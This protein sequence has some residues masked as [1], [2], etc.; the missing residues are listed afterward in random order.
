MYLFITEPRPTNDRSRSVRVCRSRPRAPRRFPDPTLQDIRAKIG[1]ESAIVFRP[2]E[3]LL[4]PRPWFSGRVVLI[5]DTVHATTPHL[6]AGPCIGIED[7]LVLAEEL[8]RAS[9]VGQAL[10]A[11][12][13]AAGSAAGWSSRTPPGSAR[14]R[15]P[16]ATKPSTHR[17]CATASW[18][19]RRRAEPH[20]DRRRRLDDGGQTACGASRRPLRV[21][22][23]LEGCR[24]TPQA[25][26]DR[27]VHLPRERRVLGPAAA[28]AE[29]HLPE[30]R[31]DAAGVSAHAARHQA[32][33]LSRWR[34]RRGRM[35]DADHAQRHPPGRALALPFH[36]DAKLGGS[37]P[38][39]RSTRCRWTGASVRG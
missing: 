26:V 7:A 1:P 30:A 9:D 10:E 8:G 28:G 33:G 27:P 15:L 5:G 19:W 35:G 24:V 38:R 16:G 29:D 21:L 36:Q 31:R 25:A 34:S 20:A 14:S 6:A 37:G 32:G 11:W 3:R 18:H 4:M 12:Q 22:H 23:E 39:S 17:S 2:I 13:S